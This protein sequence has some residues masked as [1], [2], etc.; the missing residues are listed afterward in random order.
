M[1]K[2]EILC[3]TQAQKNVKRKKNCSQRV[4]VRLSTDGTRCSFAP[5]SP[6]VMKY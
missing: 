2:N 3:E 5:F 6:T 1:V 4:G